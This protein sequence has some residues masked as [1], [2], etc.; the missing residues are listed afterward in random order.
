MDVQHDSNILSSLHQMVPSP[1][2]EVEHFDPFLAGSFGDQ[3]WLQQLNS[4]LDLMPANSESLGTSPDGCSLAKPL[5][6][7]MIA[8]MYKNVVSFNFDIIDI[9]VSHHCS[10]LK[11]LIFG[12]LSCLFKGDSRDPPQWDPLMGSF[13]YYSHTTPIRI[14]KD[15]G[16]VW[17]AYHKG[18]QGVPLLVVPEKFP[19]L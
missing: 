14:P 5:C 13:P 12:D 19:Y 7:G 3:P 8:K 6:C 15:M 17:E 16:M 9:I 4:I 2:V 18:G 1:D 10:P 11:Q